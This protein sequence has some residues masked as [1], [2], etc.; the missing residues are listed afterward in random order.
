MSEN[1]NNTYDELFDEDQPETSGLVRELRKALKAQQKVVKDREAELTTVRSELGSL[2][3]A[4]SSRTLAQLL[5]SKGAKPSLAKYMNGVEPTE[6]AV[7]KW[8]TENGDDF[9]YTPK[10]AD[11][12]KP[13]EE[14]GKSDKVEL[15]PAMQA[16]LESMAKVQNQEANAAPSL[17]AG[18]DKALEFLQRVGQNAKSYEDVENALRQAGMFNQS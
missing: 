6:E 14:A 13:V 16:A 1:D 8:L 10:A 11:D 15:D 7:V 2:K 9:G 5:E 4:E 3:A 18:E 17:I 12:G